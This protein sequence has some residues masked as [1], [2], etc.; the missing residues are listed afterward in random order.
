MESLL[1]GAFLLVVEKRMSKFL[2]SAGLLPIPY[3]IRKNPLMLSQFGP[4]LE[5]LMM[6]LSTAF[7]HLSILL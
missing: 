5:N 2:A 7:F 4:K 6:I 3:P 1:F